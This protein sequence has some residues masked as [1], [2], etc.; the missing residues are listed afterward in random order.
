MGSKVNDIDK[1][2]GENYSTWRLQ[3][4]CVLICENLWTSVHDDPPEKPTQESERKNEKALAT[5]MLGLN[6]DLL[7]LISHC[8]TAKEAWDKIEKEFW[9]DTPSR[10]VSLYKQLHR[11]NLSEFSGVQ[12][13]LMAFTTIADQL[14][15]FKVCFDED[16]L[17]II[18]L[19]SLPETYNTFITAIETQK[20]LPNLSE[21][22]VKI[23]EEYKRQNHDGT[24]GDQELAMYAKRGASKPAYL[25]SIC[26]KR[27]HLA[28]FC[29]TKKFNCY[30]CGQLGHLA[31]D[32]PS[33]KSAELADDQPTEKAFYCRNKGND[34]GER[35]IVQRYGNVAFYCR[36]AAYAA[37]KRLRSNEFILDSGA[38]CHYISNDS[39]LLNKRPHREFIEIA[40]GVEL[41]S[42]YIGDLNLLSKYGTVTL[43][44]VR[45]VPTLTVNLISINKA[46]DGELEV[47][48]KNHGAV[49]VDNG[50]VILTARRENGIFI[51][52]S[53]GTKGAAYSVKDGQAE[54]NLVRWHRRFG[55]L[56]YQAI[57]GLHDRG[58]IV[59]NDFSNIQ[60]PQCEVCA[61]C[62][63]TQKPYP[64]SASRKSAHLLEVIH[65]D[66]CG[67]F[68]SA[69]YSGSKYYC[70]FIDDASRYTYLYPM[71]NKSDLPR[72]FKEFKNM[73]E[74]LT[75]KRIKTLR[76]DNGAEYKG[77]QFQDICKESGIRHETTVPHSPQQNGVAERM[78]RTL[79][80]MA[81]CMIEDSKITDKR[82]WAEAI[83]TSCYLRNRSPNQSLGGKTPYEVFFNKAAQ[84][85]HLRVF[86]SRAIALEK[87]R[88]V[89]KFQPRGAKYTFVG[90]SELQKGYRL[91]DL[92]NGKLVISR[93]VRIFEADGNSLSR[94]SNDN[95][96]CEQEEEKLIINNEVYKNE[97]SESE[98]EKK[99]RIQPPRAAKVVRE[100]KSPVSPIKKDD[101]EEP[102]SFIDAMSGN[103]GESW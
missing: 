81:R 69:S 55:H 29:K 76:S 42:N 95:G 64:K 70:T 8:K 56:N 23:A 32:C 40:D 20:E 48:F 75:N 45:C 43:K 24:K 65:S 79:N 90:Y 83:I 16:M 11:L 99:I 15:E 46:V 2:D 51:V 52:N 84:S 57:N 87:G 77:A 31:R 14:N 89:S 3:M 36:N 59:D 62:K 60:L 78:N 5:I 18:L 47:H 12:E 71:K 10:K 26:N 38:S 7:V 93:D 72:I 92:N 50:K 66:I 97:S 68:S 101:K 103:T 28:K 63:I 96:S 73:V 86:G 9:R 27:G 21:L 53:R 98:E 6:K 67:P 37:A 91:I 13:Y 85:D 88:R 39:F 102:V 100:D 30:N 1:L 41:E 74:N 49:I 35:K 17:V 19:D 22:K 94:P 33:N 58:I 34:L 61:M 4:K 25:C 44:N 54:N 82:I 80:D